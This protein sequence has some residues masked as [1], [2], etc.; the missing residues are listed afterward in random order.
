MVHSRTEFLAFI[1]VVISLVAASPIAGV[2]PSEEAFRAQRLAMV[3]QQIARRGVRNALVL[4]AM[5]KVSRHRFVPAHLIARAYDDTPLPI[6]FGQTISQP[7]IVGYMTDALGVT[8]AHRV[9]E[10]GTGSG[11]QAAV[12]AEL[13]REVYTIEIVPDLAR[14]AGAT[15]RGLGYANV[16]VREADGYR[17]WPEQAPFDRIM[18]TAAPEQIPQALLDQLARGGR[19]VIP[20][21]AQGAVQ[22]MTIVDKTDR[23]IIQRRTIPVQFVPLI[24]GK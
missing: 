19:L 24:R 20:V 12:L 2:Q 6:G 22:D 7:F 17:G 16:H 1:C 18:V 10:I 9:L 15:L 11:Y 14:R 5:R 4:E 3:E 8:K 13:A 23:G 21:G